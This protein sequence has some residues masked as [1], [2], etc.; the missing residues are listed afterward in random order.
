MGSMTI[1]TPQGPQLTAGQLIAALVELPGHILI[2]MAGAGNSN[3]PFELGRHRPHADGVVIRARYER[4]SFMTVEIFKLMLTQHA[5]QEPTVPCPYPATMASTLWASHHH[6][7]EFRVVTG[8]D[9]INDS[10]YLRWIDVAPVQGPALQRITDVEVL[11]RNA[12]LAGRVD[13]NLDPS[14][15]GTGAVRSSRGTRT[16]TSAGALRCSSSSRPAGPSCSRSQ[17][18]CAREHPR[19]GDTRSAGPAG[20]G[21]RPDGEPRYRRCSRRRAGTRRLTDREPR[22]NRFADGGKGQRLV[23]RSRPVG[24]SLDGTD[25]QRTGIP[26]RQRDGARVRRW[27]PRCPCGRCSGRLLAEEES[28]QGSTS[29]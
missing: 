24:D 8:I 13:A 12:E 9:V 5:S 17:S 7:L 2:H 28:R 26:D 21:L 1:Q 16:R 18:S 15:G 19:Q 14:S 3:V 22:G 6:E 11:Q 25:S 10:A 20:Q 29:A 23:S 4:H 27:H